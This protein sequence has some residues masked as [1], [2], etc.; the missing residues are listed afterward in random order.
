MFS[1]VCILRSVAFYEDAEDDSDNGDASGDVCVIPL[2]NS[3]GLVNR[4]MTIV[5]VSM[6][7]CSGRSAGSDDQVGLHLWAELLQHN[8]RGS[9][10]G[11]L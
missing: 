7:G 8:Q 11:E 4:M 3:R 6:I 2:C 5:L 9:L 10:L 1:V